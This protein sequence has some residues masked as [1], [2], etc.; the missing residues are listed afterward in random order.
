[1]YMD[2]LSELWDVPALNV[3]FFLYPHGELF[4]FIVVELF[5]EETTYL[6][7]FDWFS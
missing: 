5:E 1:M 6:K 4:N 2:F 3:T 7:L